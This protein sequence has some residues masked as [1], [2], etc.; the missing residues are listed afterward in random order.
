MGHL[1]IQGVSKSFGQK[2][3]LRDIQLNIAEGEFISIL[4]PSGSGKSTLFHVIGGLLKPDQG[5]IFLHDQ[6]ITGKR[7]FISY[8]P[9]HHALFP[10][11]T[12]LQNVL[13]GQELQGG[14]QD[15]Q[16][17]FDMIHKAGLAGYEH[18]LPDALS[19]GM[20]QR[21]SFIRA[22]LNPQPLILLDEPFSALDDFTRQDMQKWLQSV[23]MEYRR[24][25]LFITH[26]IEEAL[27]LS[28][29]IAI[30]STNPATVVKQFEV[31]FERP[32]TGNLVLSN[33]FL[34]W[35]RLVANHIAKQDDEN[36]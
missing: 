29:R 19:G 23:W 28:D 4:G 22:L 27:F 5:S 32:R 18:S 34:E 20:K 15:Q 31:P 36:A 1:T 21:A 14:K 10:W 16:K 13:L 3:V 26:N 2:E 24:T 6:E 11:R 9:Q 8:M 25:I 17:A 33:E 30:L 35:K 7:G 12:V